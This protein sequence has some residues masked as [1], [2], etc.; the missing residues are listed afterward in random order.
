MLPDP[1]ILLHTTPHQT[2]CH[3]QPFIISPLTLSNNIIMVYYYLAT[4]LIDLN[5]HAWNFRTK[6]L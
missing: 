4:R 5:E 6:N 3:K 2:F 1:P